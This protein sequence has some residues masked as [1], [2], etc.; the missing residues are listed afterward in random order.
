MQK[1]KMLICS[2]G[3]STHTGF[4]KEIIH[5]LPQLQKEYDV[6]Y[7][8]FMERQ[9]SEFNG[10]KVIAAARD[11]PNDPYGN[12]LDSVLKEIKPDFIFMNQDIQINHGYVISPGINNGIPLISWD[13]IDCGKLPPGY[14][15][16]P[17]NV[18]YHIFQTEYCKSCF[19]TSVPYLI[20][21]NF[22]VVY[23]PVSLK[24]LEYIEKEKEKKPQAVFFCNAKNIPRKYLMTLIDAMYLLKSYS[25][26]FQV[27]IH[28]HNIVGVSPDIHSLINRKG[29][30]NIKFT[31]EIFDKQFLDDEELAYF[32]HLSDFFVLP[33]G[34][35]GLGIPF[36][37]AMACG[38]ICI[39]TKCTT[40]EELIGKD[41]GLLI[42]PTS[43]IY[44]SN[45]DSI[46]NYIVSP[47]DLADCMLACL[48]EKE[49][50]NIFPELR[51]N[52]YDYVRNFNP[53]R[54][55]RQ[56]ISHINKFL[57]NKKEQEKIVFTHP[58]KLTV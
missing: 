20:N 48:T 33:T 21:N 40:V 10:V 44:E 39:G 45:S 4:S 58:V 17:L 6:T 24:Y 35:E 41:R 1:R 29:I 13:I 31:H 47:K 51:Q 23:P 11:T 25:N 14:F 53:E 54:C 34:R 28:T 52:A 32:Y 18:D 50:H 43:F 38:S 42:E 55:S 2:D 37:E 57:D 36:L 46:I 7:Y 15:S 30:T 3:P 56:L 49:L 12:R 16:Y 26:L 19:E 8:G 5:I 22:P 27:I 9:D